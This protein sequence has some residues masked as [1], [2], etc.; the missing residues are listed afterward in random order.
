VLVEQLPQPLGTG[1]AVACCRPHL[2]SD[3][4]IVLN[5]DD[6]FSPKGISDLAQTPLGLLGVE[7]EDAAQ[8]GVIVTDQTDRVLR[9]HE[10]P[11]ADLYPSPVLVNIGAY[12]FDARIFDYAIPMSAR[13]EYEITDTVSWLA[14]RARVQAIRS[15]FWFP[16]GTPENLA[17]AQFLDPLLFSPTLF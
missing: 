15:D 17:D 14:G 11:P 7:R 4:F 16:I 5:G 3:Q 6:L 2:Q 12:K 1:H 9:L 10:K 13:G 8:Y